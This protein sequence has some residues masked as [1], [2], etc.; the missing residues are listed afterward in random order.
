MCVP[1]RLIARLILEEKP[2][3]VFGDGSTSRDYTYI[4]D[5]ID[6]I[7]KSFKYIED[8]QNVYEILNLGESEPITLNQMIGTIEKVLN[9]KAKI[10]RLPMQPGDVDR[11]YADITKA[12]KLIDYKPKTSFE[13]GILNF[14]NW[15][16]ENKNLYS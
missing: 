2:I 8:N 11:T 4:Q 1:A 6:G 5:I 16:K 10:N 14:Y 13:Q 9:K 3:P 15:Y 12:K 7:M